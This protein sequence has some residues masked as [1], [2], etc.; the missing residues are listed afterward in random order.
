MA[1]GQASVWSGSWGGST[2][3]S[4]Q[5][6]GRTLGASCSPCAGRACAGAR[7]GRA[8]SPSSTRFPCPRCAALTAPGPWQEPSSRAERR[9]LLLS[10]RLLFVALPGG[11]A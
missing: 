10:H 3:P 1:A 8:G 5:G 9:L 11:A 4:T 2:A 7:A 6:C